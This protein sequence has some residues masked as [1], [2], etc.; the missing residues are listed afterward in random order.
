MH[1]VED[2]THPFT[3]EKIDFPFIVAKEKIWLENM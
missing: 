1:L 3:G 2:Y